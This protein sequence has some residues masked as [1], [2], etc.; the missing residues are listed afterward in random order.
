[1]RIIL[2]SQSPRRKKILNDAGYVIEVL[3]AYF[4]EES[5]RHDDPAALTKLLAAA[6]NKVLRERVTG[7]PCIITADTVVTHGG[8]IYE[9]AQS[10][11]EAYEWISSFM[12]STI[13]IHTSH[14]IHDMDTKYESEHT[15]LAEVHFTY[16]PDDVRAVLALNAF[17]ASVA[18][19]FNMSDPVLKPYVTMYGDA[20]TVLGLDIT[21]VRATL[22]H[23]EKMHIRNVLKEEYRAHALSA[24]VD[25][26][27]AWVSHNHVFMSAER[28][29]AYHP[30]HTLE[31]PFID[32]LVNRYPEKQWVFPDIHGEHLFFPHTEALVSGSCVLVPSLGISAAGARLGKGKGYYDRFLSAHADLQPYTLSVVPDFA[33]RAALPVSTHDIPI[34]H[35]HGALQRLSF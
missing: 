26:A 14:M 21:W 11:H 30:I 7:K 18:G 10:E 19:G 9:K 35:V 6:K 20:S 22:T 4:D 16:I 12:N 1:M 13:T 28:V 23:I 8:R 33:L 29:Y 31:I 32:T 25:D 17:E 24:Y 5:V 3:P 15:S 34:A 2:G 27:V